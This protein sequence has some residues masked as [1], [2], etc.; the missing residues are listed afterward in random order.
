M[1][2]S[3]PGTLP[4]TVGTYYRTLLSLDCYPPWRYDPST[5]FRTEHVLAILR[6]FNPATLPSY[7]KPL[8]QPL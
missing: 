7:S 8:R 5:A 3:P 1:C 6:T 2:S 4:D